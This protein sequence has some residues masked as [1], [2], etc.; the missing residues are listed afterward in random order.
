ML[1]DRSVGRVARAFPGFLTNSLT[2][3][4][5]CGVDI[6]LSPSD[7]GKKLEKL[8]KEYCSLF[9]FRFLLFASFL[10]ACL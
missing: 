8:F 4:L 9:F 6:S 7:K 1:I 5:E 2:F 10:D 3:S